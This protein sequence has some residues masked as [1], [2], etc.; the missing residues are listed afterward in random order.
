MRF[1]AYAMA[2]AVALFPLASAAVD[3]VEINAIFAMT[4]SG[5]FVGKEEAASLAVVENLVN[6]NGG[7]DGRPLH[8]VIADDTSTPQ[9]A[10]QLAAGLVAKRAAVILGST[11]VGD[12][13]AMYG[14]VKE[15]A[16]MYCMSPI[17]HEDGSHY[18]FS[19]G[20]SAPDA[21]NFVVGFL[22]R[23]NLHRV[24]I[25]SSTDASG[26]VAA[27]GCDAAFAASENKS[28]TLVAREQFNP[29][30][31]SVDAQISRIKGAGA[32][33]LISFNTGTALGTVL[34]ALADI[35]FDVP[36]VTSPAN[37]N[38]TF[39]KQYSSILPRRFWLYGAPSDAPDAVTSRDLVAALKTYTDAFA[40]AGMTPDHTLASV[41]DPA[42][43]VVTA[44]R[45]LGPAASATEIEQYI[46]GLHGWAGVNGE[47]DFRDGSQRGLASGSVI[48]LQ[49]NAAQGRFTG[50]KP[51]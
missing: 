42:L 27:D 24:G 12:C 17:F 3:P 31:I 15:S 6:G 22:R 23:S 30:D 39:V 20:V 35:G 16:V 45:K 13:N 7:I 32:Q 28:M 18:A 10:V 19:V 5:S 34:H 2:A 8:F 11:L 26:K 29:N 47:Y 49:W 21:C 25:I 14:V 4:G 51:G 48:M 50:V 43:I 1:L 44:L 38:Y 40:A 46:N 41:W 9:V 37:L 36:V 33:A